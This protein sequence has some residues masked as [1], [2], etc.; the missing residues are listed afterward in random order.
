MECD[1][2]PTAIF[3]ELYQ[4]Q[5]SYL[6]QSLLSVLGTMESAIWGPRMPMRMGF[7]SLVFIPVLFCVQQRPCAYAQQ[8]E[9][10]PVANAP[11]QTARIVETLVSRNQERAQSLHGYVGTRVYQV[12]YHGF[13]GG[14]TAEMIVDV[15]YRS[16]ETK[17]FTVRSSTGSIVI[18]ERVFKKLLQSEKD[19][20]SRE[21]QKRTALNSDNY[22]FTQVGYE[23]TPSGLM[24]VLAVQPKRKDKFLYEGRIWVDARA[25]AVARLEPQPAK[26]PSFWTKSSV[27][28][29]VY[30]PVGEFWLPTR[31]RSVG[32]IRLGGTAELTIQYNE[33]RLVNGDEVNKVSA[34]DSVAPAG[35]IHA[36][37]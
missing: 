24:Y 35:S 31:N 34:L 21:A 22:S 1:S 11:L 23:N 6:A 14:R 36:Q 13:P 26:N 12:E 4:N 17:E 33:Y 37:R 16:P 18:V 25:F 8:G 32:E 3:S 28:E 7:Q 29:Q 19:A 2:A 27:I 20:S 15:K 10:V 30:T 9:F 5:V